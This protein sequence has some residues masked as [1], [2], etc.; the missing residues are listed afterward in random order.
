MLNVRTS[1]GPT[2]AIVNRALDQMIKVYV[3]VRMSTFLKFQHSRDF[4]QKYIN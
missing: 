4:E 3:M 2:N 1:L